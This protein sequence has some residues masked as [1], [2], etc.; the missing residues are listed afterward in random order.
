MYSFKTFLKEWGL[1]ILILSLLALSR[2]F[3]W[4]NVRVEG[5]SMD[6]T[7]ADGEVLFVV[8]TSP[9]QSF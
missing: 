3:L 4:S 1:T 2:I 5:H 9:N 8:K 7:L 6:P